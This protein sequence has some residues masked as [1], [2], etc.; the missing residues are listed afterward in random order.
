MTDPTGTDNWLVLAKT[1]R[2]RTRR[3]LRRLPF[4]LS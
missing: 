4:L 3:P 2:V 1:R